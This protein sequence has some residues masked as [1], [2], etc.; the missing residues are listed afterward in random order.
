MCR[1]LAVFVCGC[2]ALIAACRAGETFT[3]ADFEKGTDGFRGAIERDRR[4]AKL[5]PA[6]SR[7][8]GRSSMPARHP[9]FAP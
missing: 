1:L 6:G 3:I 4:V 9:A 2:V 8:R 7:L 5:G